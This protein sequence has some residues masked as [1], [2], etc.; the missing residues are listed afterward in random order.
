MGRGACVVSL[1][2][3][4]WGD[5]GWRGRAP[6]PQITERCQPEAS[7][8][9]HLTPILP[10]SP[11]CLRTAC[12]LMPAALTCSLPGVHT[13]CPSRYGA[14][15]YSGPRACCSALRAAFSLSL[16]LFLEWREGALLG[17]G[18]VFAGQSGANGTP[19]S[20]VHFLRLCLCP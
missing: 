18:D 6:S 14:H 13:L 17:R 5:L 15:T 3:S 20:E 8:F 9:L 10:P 19:F 7:L 2:H 16:L 1:V 4:E 12:S 11:S